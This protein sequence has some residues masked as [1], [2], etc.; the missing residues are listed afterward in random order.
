M[1]SVS[2]YGFSLTPLL[3]LINSYKVIPIVIIEAHLA[4][5]S[6]DII[7]GFLYIVYTLL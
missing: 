5:N 1:V 7:S 2:A 4:Y 3:S 6:N